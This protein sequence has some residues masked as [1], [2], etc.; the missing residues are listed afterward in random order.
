MSDEGLLSARDLLYQQSQ[1]N[2]LG[3]TGICFV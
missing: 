3:E 1:E 2:Q